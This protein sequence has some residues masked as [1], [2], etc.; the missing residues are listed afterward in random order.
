M[1][2][3]EVADWAPNPEELCWASELRDILVEAIEK[4]HPTLRTVFI[5]RD[6]E[7]L[8]IS[9]TALALDLSI[10]AVKTRLFR[11]RLQLREL[12]S[13]YFRRHTEYRDQPEDGHLG[14]GTL[15]Q[16]TVERSMNHNIKLTV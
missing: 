5:L 1:L 13:D 15:Q 7:E 9:Q 8:S 11:A 16:Q 4:L 14:S 3:R 6:V 12:L 10:P 2:P